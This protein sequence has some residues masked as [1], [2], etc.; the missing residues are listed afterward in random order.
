MSNEINFCVIYTAL[1][2]A[3]EIFGGDPKSID[4]T[5]LG[6]VCRAMDCNPSLDTLEKLGAAKKKGRSIML[7]NEICL[8][9]KLQTKLI[10]LFRREDIETRGDCSHH[11][12]T[13][14]TEER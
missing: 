12:R 13:Q 5:S 1:E 10:N 14:E 9:Y 3:L 8:Q 4:S 6:D 11:S 7:L 2:F